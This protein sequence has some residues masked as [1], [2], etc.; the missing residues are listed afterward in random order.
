MSSGGRRFP[1]RAGP[2]WVVGGHDADGPAAVG[3]SRRRRRL[4][5]PLPVRVAAAA[6]VTP[7]YLGQ[8]SVAAAGDG[9]DQLVA[10]GQRP[11]GRWL[12]DEMD[13]ACMCFAHTE[14]ATAS[15]R[16]W[17]ERCEESQT[18]LVSPALLGR[19]WAG[20]SVSRPVHAP[21]DAD[22]V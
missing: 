18:S 14:P 13:G 19:A 12:T 17:A 15:G 1:N 4:Q 3:S 2:H 7:G 9:L 6:V 8:A 10:E 22:L 16:R 20:G 5:P 11:S 21:C